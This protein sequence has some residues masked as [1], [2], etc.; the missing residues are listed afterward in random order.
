MNS[1]VLGIKGSLSMAVTKLVDAQIATT[2][3][4]PSPIIANRSSDLFQALC[5]D[6]TMLRDSELSLVAFVTTEI[7]PFLSVVAMVKKE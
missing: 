1:K 4:N 3:A 6:F 5:T 7:L 2:A